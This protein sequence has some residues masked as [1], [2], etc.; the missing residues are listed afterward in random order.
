MIGGAG[1]HPRRD[2][3]F[4]IDAGPV[5][6]PPSP[7]VAASVA[8]GFRIGSHNDCLL[9]SQTDVGR[10]SED[11]G[12]R[13]TEQDYIGLIGDLSPFGGERC[14]PADD[15]GAAPRT[16]CSDILREGARYNLAYLKPD[17]IGDCSTIRDRR[18]LLQRSGR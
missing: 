15:P 9:A 6:V 3:T 4:T 11:A 14:N 5:L 2:L 17:Y 12:A 16:T 1:H 13:A 8:G 18:R 7:G 10:F